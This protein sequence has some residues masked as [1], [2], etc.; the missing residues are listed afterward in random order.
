MPMSEQQEIS[1]R[2][3][4]EGFTLLKAMGDWLQSERHFLHLTNSVAFV[5]GAIHGPGGVVIR[6]NGT[7]RL[8]K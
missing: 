6:A 8:P 4:P 7:F 1:A 3:I 5:A 2:T